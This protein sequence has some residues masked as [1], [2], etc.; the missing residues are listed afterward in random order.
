[1]EFKKGWR[2][3]L[4]F[5]LVLLLIV[6]FMVHLH[7]L[8]AAEFGDPAIGDGQHVTLSTEEAGLELSWDWDRHGQT[9]DYR[10]IEDSAAHLSTAVAIANTTERNLTIAHGNNGGERHFAVIAVMA[11]DSEV[12]VGTAS[13]VVVKGPMEE[14]MDSPYVRIFTGGRDDVS[15]DDIEGFLSIELFSWFFVLAGFYTG[16]IAV[17]TLGD[18]LSKRRMDILLSSP[19]P[20]K[21]YILEKFAALAVFLFLMLFA[22]G[23]VMYLSVV[24]IGES[25]NLGLSES[26]LS[27]LAAWPLLLAVISSGFLLAVMAKGSQGAVGVLFGLLLLQYVM[28]IM[29]HMLESLSFLRVLTVT[30]YWDYNAILMDG[31]FSGLN[32]LILCVLSLVLLLATLRAFERLDIPS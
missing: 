32:F 16:Y 3:Y 12:P 29:G 1:M 22:T 21:R 20:R 6:A 26:L 9:V 19:L 14:F 27:M 17:R 11:D 23:A 25:A 7:P 15:M 10:I 30:S 28:G 8:T 4:T 24:N 13:T 18:D 5:T 31:N 2:G